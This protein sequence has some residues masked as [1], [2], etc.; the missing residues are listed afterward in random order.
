MRS[1]D[2]ELPSNRTFGIFLALIS[3]A[4]AIYFAAYG[5]TGG[6]WAAGVAALAFGLLAQL[7]PSLLSPL[8]KA[9][10]LLGLALATVVNP[11]VMGIIFLLLFTPLAIALRW[12]GRDELRLRPA[13]AG[14]SYWRRRDPPGPAPVS[15]RRQF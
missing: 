1:D 14:T 2:L 6:A 15:F 9:W 12:A 5:K 8:N 13:P 10:N 4:A 11:I 3:V 7:A